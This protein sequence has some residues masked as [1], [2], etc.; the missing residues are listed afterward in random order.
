MFPFDGLLCLTNENL[1]C[2]LYSCN[3]LCAW[4]IQYCSLSAPV[5]R[6][7]VKNQWRGRLNA[8]GQVLFSVPAAKRASYVRTRGWK[9][10]VQHALQ[11]NSCR[12][13]IVYLSC[14]CFCVFCVTAS[15]IPFI[16]NVRV[17][18]TIVI[19]FV[20]SLSIAQLSCY[21][22]LRPG[23][24]VHPSDSPQFNVLTG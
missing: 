1:P 24:L 11:E 9:S 23:F 14:R 10:R 21:H 2:S 19:A 22:V 13:V 12:F 16:F 20:M 6:C 18:R 8:W 4:I 15:L 5:V 7:V 3:V 17:V